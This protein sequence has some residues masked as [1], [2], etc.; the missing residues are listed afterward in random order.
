MTSP[1]VVAKAE[2]R[3][4]SSDAA[5]EVSLDGKQWRPVA[6]DGL[7]QQVRGLYRYLMRI[8]FRRPIRSLELT[9]LVQH[10]Q[11]ALPY[12]APGNNTITISAANP[13]ALGRRRDAHS[14][15]R[16]SIVAEKPRECPRS[17]GTQ[18]HGCGISGS[19]EAQ[20]AGMSA[21]AKQ[22]GDIRARWA[23]AEP[24]VWTDRMLTALE[25]AV[26]GGACFS[27]HRWPN[28]FFAELGLIAGQANRPAALRVPPDAYA[29]SPK[30]FLTAGPLQP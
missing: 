29:R 5:L 16:A 6:A 20:P 18:G 9:S 12:L 17:K 24:S 22:A 10:N 26:K 23:L 7:T 27:H 25:T 15:V 13:K 8:T 21:T 28:A 19:T 11:E 1:Y 2:V 3:I 30:G 14:G 4:D